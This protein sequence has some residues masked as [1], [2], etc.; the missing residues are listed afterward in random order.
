MRGEMLEITPVAAKF[1]RIKLDDAEKLALRMKLDTF[2]VT[3]VPKK[4]SDKLRT[5]S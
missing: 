4:V 2:L 1:R 5:K 3:P